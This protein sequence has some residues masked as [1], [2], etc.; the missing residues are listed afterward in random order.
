MQSRTASSAHF[1]S[2]RLAVAGFA[3]LAL[4]AW[5]H[6]GRTHGSSLAWS[7]A[8]SLAG[9]VTGGL[10]FLHCTLVGGLGDFGMRKK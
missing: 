9:V 3:S 7:E 5:I 10:S 1:P 2:V 4:L 6:P 8:G